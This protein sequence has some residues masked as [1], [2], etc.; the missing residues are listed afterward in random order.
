MYPTLPTWNYNGVIDELAIYNTALSEEEISHLYCLSNNFGVG[1][2]NSPSL[3]YTGG[4]VFSATSDVV[5]EA[6]LLDSDGAGMDGYGIEFIFDGVSVGTATTDIDGIASLNIGTKDANVYEAYAKVYCLENE[7]VFIAVYDPSAGFVT[8]GGWIDSPA[9]A[10]VPDPTLYGKANFGFVSKYK[11]GQSIPDGNTEFQFKAGD[12]NFHSSNY[13]WLVI[14]GGSKA[15]FKG[16]GTINGLG[17][18]K[19][20]ITAQ[21]INVGDTFRIKIWE[22]DTNGDEIVIYD[23]GVDTVLGG[24]QIKIHNK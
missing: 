7:H 22:E 8:G 4:L 13:E 10:Y 12:L 15:M 5:L 20:M 14:T 23:N 11:K 1:Y 9:G 17:A 6:T 3:T 18:Y 21:D 19:F 16:I 2:T 24:G